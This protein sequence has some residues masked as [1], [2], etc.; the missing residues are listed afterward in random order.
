MCLC[1]STAVSSSYGQARGNFGEFKRSLNTKSYGYRLIKDPTSTGSN[2]VVEA[3]EVRNGDC[4]Y[5]EKWNDCLTDRERSELSQVNKDTQAGDEYWYGWYIYF[6]HDF[7][8]LAPAKVSLGQFHQDESHPAWMFEHTINGYFLVNQLAADSNEKSELIPETNLRGHWHKI[9][10]QVVWQNNE[11]GQ[12]NVWVNGESK[13]KYTGPTMDAK[14]V[15]FKYGLYR[16]FVSR[17]QSSGRTGVNT[18]KNINTSEKP[19]VLTP[20]QKVYFSNVKRA[21]TRN[22]LKIKNY[23]KDE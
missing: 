13:V 11:Q 10:I 2:R 21:S 9:E 23:N 5:H 16:A 1:I 15:Y 20:S 7:I 3:F 6:P 12:F 18:R 14:R 17:Y 19:S 8:N 22:D 4:G